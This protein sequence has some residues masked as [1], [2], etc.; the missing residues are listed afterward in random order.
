MHIMRKLE[1]HN[2]TTLINENRKKINLLKS[3]IPTEAKLKIDR[4]TLI[5]E[6]LNEQNALIM[7]RQQL[8]LRRA[9]SIK[10]YY[11]SD[12]ILKVG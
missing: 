9:K 6:L 1:F 8:L 3:N 2:F 11:S 10:N 4:F 7:Q 12:K 5:N